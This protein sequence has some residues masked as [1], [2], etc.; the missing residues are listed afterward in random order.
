MCS[1]F[2]IDVYG[3]EPHQTVKFRAEI[4][5]VALTL[6]LGKSDLVSFKFAFNKYET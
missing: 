3:D 2:Y 5:T 4:K 6:Y 1:F